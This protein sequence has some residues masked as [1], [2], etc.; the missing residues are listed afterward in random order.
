MVERNE[1]IQCKAPLHRVRVIA[2][3]IWHRY[4]LARAKEEE[5]QQHIQVETRIESSGHHVA[6][7]FPDLEPIPVGPV[8]NNIPTDDRRCVSRADITVEDRQAGEEN[9]NVP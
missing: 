8:H 2:P 5:D 4:L 7:A 9:A 3:P 6:V 1:S